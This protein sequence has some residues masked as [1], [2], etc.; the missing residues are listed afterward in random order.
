MIAAGWRTGTE[1][2]RQEFIQQPQDRREALQSLTALGITGWARGSFLILILIL[3]TQTQPSASNTSTPCSHFAEHVL[4]DTDTHLFLDFSHPAWTGNQFFQ[5]GCRSALLWQP[6]TGTAAACASV[7]LQH[8][9]HGFY[10]PPFP[11]FPSHIY[12]WELK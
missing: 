1:Q 4:P 12:G 2:E 8:T 6:G 9:Q 3:G 5:W 7:G 10:F 11:F